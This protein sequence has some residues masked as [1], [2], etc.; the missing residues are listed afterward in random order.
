MFS[1]EFPEGI[2]LDEIADD[3]RSRFPPRR[4][5]QACFDP[6]GR[7]AVLDSQ[8]RADLAQAH[9]IRAELRMFLPVE[10]VVEALCVIAE[11]KRSS[12]DPMV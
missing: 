2:E 8:I 9:R 6:P 11:S 5:E 1:A 12:L 10:K 4:P 7:L 3:A